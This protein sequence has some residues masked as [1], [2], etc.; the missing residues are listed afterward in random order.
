MALTISYIF[1][2]PG[3]GLL[4]WLRFVGWLKLYVGFS[5]GCLSG[6]CAYACVCDLCGG[7]FGFV[8]AWGMV[9]VGGGGGLGGSVLHMGLA[10]GICFSFRALRLPH[11]F[12]I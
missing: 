4:R 6:G 7:I 10:H 5:G 11:E 1:R 8:G 12:Q 2:F 3:Q 9:F